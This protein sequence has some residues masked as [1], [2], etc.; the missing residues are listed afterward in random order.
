MDEEKVIPDLHAPASDPTALLSRGGR[1]DSDQ[2]LQETPHV[3]QH[4]EPRC[5]LLVFRLNKA[6]SGQG[7]QDAEAH[8]TRIGNTA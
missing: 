3:V 2:T 6:H 1:F 8:T 4:A 7:N 5:A